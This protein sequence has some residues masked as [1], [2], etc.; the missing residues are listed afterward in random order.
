MNKTEYN[1]DMVLNNGVEIPRIGF[2]TYKMHG[3]E[4][5]KAL[6]TA[7][8]VGYRHIDTATDYGNEKEIGQALQNIGIKREEL[9][10]T[11]KVWNDDQG[12]EKTLK[13]I[14]VSLENLQMDFLDLYLVHWPVPRRREATWEAMIELYDER[15]TRSLGVSNYMPSHIE[16]LMKKSPLTPVVNQIEVTP[17]LYQKSLIEK[18]ESYDIK[19]EA[20]S[21]LVRGTKMNEPIIVEIAKEHNK[22]SAQV[23]IRWSLQKG[24]VVLPKSANP[25][26]IKE[27]FDVFD[28]RLTDKN[29]SNIDALNSNYRISWDPSKVL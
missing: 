9:F 11:T 27:N 18:C 19:I 10:I 3:Y 20:H 12:Y 26:R 29:M 21:P 6:E 22:T 28:F 4:L 25:I 2:G 7:I 24:F 15:K 8:E 1:K 5:E 23:L 14:E 16:E 17:Y 13:A